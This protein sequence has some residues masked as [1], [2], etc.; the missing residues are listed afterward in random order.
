MRACASTAAAQQASQ[1]SIKVGTRTLFNNLDFLTGAKNV[2]LRLPTAAAESW[3]KLGCDGRTAHAQL[4]VFGYRSLF[5][6]VDGEISCDL[7]MFLFC[8]KGF[9]RV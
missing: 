7:G 2:K 9:I 8:F 4:R 5:V 3:L 1:W 6:L